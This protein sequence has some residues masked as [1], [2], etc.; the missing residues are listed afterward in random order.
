MNYLLITLIRPET[1]YRN[2]SMREFLSHYSNLKKV[3]LFEVKIKKYRGKV[4]HKTFNLTLK[5]FI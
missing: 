1:E 5:Y 2:R 3:D 4:Y